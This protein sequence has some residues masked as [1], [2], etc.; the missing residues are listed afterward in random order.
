MPPERIPEKA[1]ATGPAAGTRARS[2]SPEKTT[3]TGHESYL[4]TRIKSH[5]NLAH[6]RRPSQAS[7]AFNTSSDAASAQPIPGYFPESSPPE[8]PAANLSLGA[9][10]ALPKPTVTLASALG[11]TSKHSEAAQKHLY[12]ENFNEPEPPL[13]VADRTSIGGTGRPEATP[14][15]TTWIPTPEDELSSA[16]KRERERGNRYKAQLLSVQKLAKEH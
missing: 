8:R 4:S 11:Q 2:H 12:L 1:Q 7:I 6:T 5:D 9:T 14:T 16:I 15:P 10:P 3:N 13:T